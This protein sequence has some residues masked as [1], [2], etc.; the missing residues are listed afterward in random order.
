MSENEEQYQSKADNSD[1]DYPYETEHAL[2]EE[3]IF[4]NK[5]DSFSN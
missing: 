4:K 3:S 2:D 1:N 5:N